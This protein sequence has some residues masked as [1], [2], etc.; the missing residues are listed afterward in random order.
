MG[1]RS[2]VDDLNWIFVD[3][4]TGQLYRSTVREF[5]P[6]GLFT[7]RPWWV[8]PVAFGESELNFTVGGLPD[9]V[10]LEVAVVVVGLPVG[11]AP[12]DCVGRSACS[13]A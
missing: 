1:N 3:A 4:V 2:V 10:V 12:C 11:Q 9:V 8:F 13:R 7:D 6:C 5:T